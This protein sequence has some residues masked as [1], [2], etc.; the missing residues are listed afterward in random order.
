MGF[1]SR[2]IFGEMKNFTS[3]K[4]ILGNAVFHIEIDNTNSSRLIF[5]E[6]GS[7]KTT[8]GVST[9][10]LAG[11]DADLGYVE[12]VGS[13]AMFN[14]LR[15]FVQLFKK[16]IVA[17]DQRNHCLRLVHRPLMQTESF[18]GKCETFG[19]KDGSPGLFHYPESVLKDA[20]SDGVYVTDD[21]NNAVRYVDLFTKRVSTFISAGLRS[22]ASL[23]FNLNKDAILISTAHY[24]S[25]YDITSQT[26][27]NFTGFLNA[28][29]KIH[30]NFTVADAGYFYPREMLSL[31]KNVTLVAD[32]NNNALRVIDE[33]ADKV[34][35]ICRG[36]RSIVEGPV[37]SC[38]ILSPESILLVDDVL[39]VGMTGGISA[40]TGTLLKQTKYIGGCYSMIY[41]VL[42][43]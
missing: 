41:I 36:R 3:F 24:L 40:M 23:A 7:I 31:N 2:F 5:I 32:Y 15:D 20:Y 10:I 22:P 33:A 18:A 38:E 39:Y 43:C 13:V 34:T 6:R 37:D 12:G 29:L 9:E 26:L 19:F 11:S 14:Y 17:V 35:P 42:I 21:Y 16:R 4:P 8:D 30:G 27:T 1:I 28:G 25:R